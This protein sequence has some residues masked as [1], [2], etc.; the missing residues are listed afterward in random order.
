LQTTSNGKS[1]KIKGVELQ[2]L[3]NF[4]VDNLLV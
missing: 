3:Q 4:L 1:T 2:K